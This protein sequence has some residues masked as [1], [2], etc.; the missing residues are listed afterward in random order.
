MLFLIQVEQ[1]KRANKLYTNDSIFLRSTLSI[2][3]GDQPLPA[4]V[5]ES[6]TAS[7]NTNPVHG[8]L[9]TSVIPENSSSEDEAPEE[10][11]EKKEDNH[12]EDPKRDTTMDFFNRIDRQL[13]QEKSK[14]AEIE[15]TSQ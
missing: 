4:H 2:P 13:R 11:P 7:A 9:Q 10:E 1:I 15:S 12:E 6:A 3:V 8:A 5:L 14:M